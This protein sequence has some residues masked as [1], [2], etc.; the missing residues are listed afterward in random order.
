MRGGGRPSGKNGLGRERN[1]GIDE[2]R[3][4]RRQRER[5]GQLLADAAHQARSRIEADRHVGSGRAGGLVEPQIVAREAIRTREQPQR[6][7]GIGRTAA[8]SGR[9]RQPL[10]EV[11]SAQADVGNTRGE[12]ARRLQHEIVGAR[13]RLRGMGPAQRE[14]KLAARRKA[15]TVAEAGKRDQ[16]FNL[17]V[18]VGAAAEYPQRQ[19]DFGRRVLDERNGRGHPSA[20]VAGLLPWRHR[21]QKT[22]PRA[23]RS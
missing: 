1:A 6:R 8:Q 2:H 21:P 11:K 19:I 5:R 13:P 3:L 20:A 12:R 17:M 18:A 15:Q 10:I 16:A 7:A 4:K 9:D 14:R 22:C 23:A